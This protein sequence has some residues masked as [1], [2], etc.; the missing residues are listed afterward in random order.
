VS[1]AAVAEMPEVTVRAVVGLQ[2]SVLVATVVRQRQRFAARNE[3]ALGGAASAH[4]VPWAFDEGTVSGDHGGI[5]RDVREPRSVANHDVT[6][7]R[8]HDT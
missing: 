3:G 2:R 5:P 6:I 1:G 4:L 7:P 8:G